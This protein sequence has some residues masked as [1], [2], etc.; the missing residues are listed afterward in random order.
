[1]LF[2]ASYYSKEDNAEIEKLVGK[3]FG[4]IKRLKMRGNGSQRLVVAEANAALAKIWASQS[5]P[6]LTSIELRPKG[7]LLWFRIKL[8]NWVLALPY[9]QL[10]II[11]SGE[12]VAIHA[13]KWKIKL[14]AANNIPLQMK[15]FQKLLSLKKE[16]SD[17]ANNSI[18]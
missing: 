8:D 15:F 4:L 17:D 2:K 13:N 5:T 10:S 14:L 9:Y 6:V 12:S 18:Q 3:A 11:K 1:M 16:F 7:I